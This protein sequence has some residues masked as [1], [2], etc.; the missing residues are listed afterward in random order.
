MGS[1][2]SWL[3]LATRE[4]QEHSSPLRDV[5]SALDQLEPDRA[6]HLARFAYLLGRVAHADQHASA[7]E[8]AAMERLV[9]YTVYLVGFGVADFEA[10]Y[11]A[12]VTFTVMAV[13]VL[14]DTKRMLIDPVPS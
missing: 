10:P 4:S 8:T 12:W 6:R 7:S 3:G 2:W 11:F 14:H 5:V 1:I 9:A 13:V